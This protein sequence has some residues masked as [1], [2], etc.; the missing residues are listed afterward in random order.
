MINGGN[1]IVSLE[2][3]QFINDFLEDITRISLD[4]GEIKWPINLINPIDHYDLG[5]IRKVS[6][7][8]TMNIFH[9]RSV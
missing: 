2:Y 8:Q 3:M 5:G 7:K 1:N 4:V 6:L 9:E